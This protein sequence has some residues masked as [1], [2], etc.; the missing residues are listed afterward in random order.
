MIAPVTTLSVCMTASRE[1]AR[2]RAILAL[3]RPIAD[4]IVLAADDRSAEAIHAACADLVD[5]PLAYAFAWPPARYIAWILH[6]CSGEWILRLD[7]DEAPSRALLDALPTLAADRRR[8]AFCLPRPPLYGSPD[9]Y[10]ASHPWYPDYQSRLLRNVPGLWS[11]DGS[12]HREPQVLGERRREPALPFY[13]LRFVIT[14]ENGRRAAVGRYDELV[15][16]L[17]TEAFPVNSMYLPEHWSGVRT[18]PVPACD[19]P[20]IAAVLEPAPPPAG[21]PPAAI[22][23][24]SVAD[25]DAYNSGREIRPDAYRAKIRISPDRPALLAG[26]IAHVE[27]AV[28]NLGSE[29]WPPAHTAAPLIRLA[30]RWLS[31]GGECVVPEGLRTPFEETVA[32]GEES[33]VMLAVQAPEEPGSYV[34]EVDVVHELVAWFGAEARMAVEIEPLD[35]PPG[36][37]RIA[38]PAGRLASGRPDEM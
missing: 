13:H 18:A 25:V 22:E 9:R 1:P 35:P 19:R 31:A 10:L 30:Y 2:V 21:P 28:R 32:P 16:D 8:S 36:R 27:V 29:R 23:H 34:L 14:P 3:L 33:V 5:R 15:P 38:R 24:H 12:A 4:E 11:S 6:Q 26:V 7:D 17:T 37:S 20:L